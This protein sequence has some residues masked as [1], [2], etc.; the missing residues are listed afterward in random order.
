MAATDF[1]S[2]PGAPNEPAPRRRMPWWA[3]LLIALGGAAVLSCASCL[4]LFAWFGATTPDTY[5]YA[6]NEVPA[7]YLRTARDLGVLADDEKVLWFYSDAMLGIKEG[8][9]LVSDRQVAIY[10]AESQPPATSVTFDQIAEVE[11]VRDTSFFVDS[12]I[13][14]TLH[15]GS[16]VSFPVSSEK[17]RDKHFFK[18]I[19]TRAPQAKAETR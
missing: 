11:L 3:W 5:V 15:D 4:G 6:A 16:V 7:D 10:I 18:A 14:L 13:T 19:T 17:D 9:Y 8:F 12:T 1:Y 2:S